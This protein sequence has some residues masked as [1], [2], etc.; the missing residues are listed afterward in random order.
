M[1]NN[2]I[3]SKSGVEIIKRGDKYFACIDEGGIGSKFIEYEVT[4]EEAKAIMDDVDHF[5]PILLKY[6]NERLR[7]EGYFD[8]KF[9][10]KYL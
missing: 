9:R 2:I 6:K 8:R 5:E 7:K 4:E 10:F 1:E 3:F